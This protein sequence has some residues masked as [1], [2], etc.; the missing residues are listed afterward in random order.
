MLGLKRRNSMNWSQTAEITVSNAPK[1][2]PNASVMSMRKNKEEKKLDPT[3]LVTT[4]GQAMKANPGPPFTTYVLNQVVSIKGTQ[5]NNSMLMIAYHFKLFT[6]STS[7]FVACAMNP[8]IENTTSPQNME[9][10]QFA[11]AIKMASK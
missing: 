1:I 9:V 3:I 6:F 7:T 10:K 8:K 4:S 11:N 5:I 2:D